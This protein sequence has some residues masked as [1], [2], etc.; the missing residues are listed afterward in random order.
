MALNLIKVNTAKGYLYLGVSQIIS[1]RTLPDGCEVATTD[2]TKYLVLE[3]A[4]VV[5]ELCNRRPPDGN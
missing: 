4:S 5:A 2:G 1:V 3:Q